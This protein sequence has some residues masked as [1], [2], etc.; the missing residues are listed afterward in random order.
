MSVLFVT[1]FNK[2]LYNITGRT[3]IQSF[4][5]HVSNADLLICYED[6]DFLEEFNR[7]KYQEKFNGTIITCDISTDTYMTNWLNENKSRIPIIYGGDALDNEPFFGKTLQEQYWANYRASR[8]FRKVVSLRHA[9][10]HYTNTYDYICVVD[11]DCVIKQKFPM[12]ALIDI[13]ENKHKMI[14]FWSEI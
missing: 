10:I 14:Y 13:F 7:E 4:I 11:C 8:Y 2:K 12:N 5:S 6:F 3:L 9:L 1:T